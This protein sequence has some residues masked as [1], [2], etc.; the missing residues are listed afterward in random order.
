MALAAVGSAYRGAYPSQGFA[1]NAFRVR[2]SYS[3]T[4]DA[5]DDI[6]RAIMYNQERIERLKASL[7]RD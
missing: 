4:V 6:E 2:L 5:P 3:M 1:A 7:K